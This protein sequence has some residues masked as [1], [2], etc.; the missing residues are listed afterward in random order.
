MGDERDDEAMEDRLYLRRTFDSAAS[1]YDRARPRYPPEL[2][3]ALVSRTGLR[4]GDQV[5][6]V[7]CATGIATQPLADR[8]LNVVCV[9]LGEE[10]ARVARDRLVAYRQI[11]VIRGDFESWASARSFDLVMAATAWHWI[12][13]NIRYQRAWEALRSGGHLAFW[14][15]THV[16]P[17]DGDPFFDEI[18]DVYDEIGEGL[19]P[20]APRPRPG[21]LP[22]SLE[23]IEHSG[24]F[25]NAV[26]LQFDWEIRYSAS[27][28]IDLLN[29]FS[30]HIAM[31][32]SQRK[33]LYSAIRGR[34]AQRPVQDIARHWGA[35]LHVA[36]RLDP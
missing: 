3:D 29:T 10:L 23:E 30:G 12:D 4:P 19:G 36:Q 31:S 32:P 5:L 20:D 27:A 15:A 14:S 33:A 7:G 1:L 22:D 24:L 17:D 2:F 16:L 11:E 9:E 34:I 26:A 35:V 13:P 18:Q 8:G 6:E 21:R 28:Y 25:F